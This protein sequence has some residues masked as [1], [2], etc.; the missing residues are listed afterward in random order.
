MDMPM[1]GAVPAQKSAGNG[2]VDDIMAYVQDLIEN[3]GMS[4]EQAKQKGLEMMMMQE[5]QGGESMGTEMAEPEM[6][7]AVQDPNAPT[8]TPED[9]TDPELE[10]NLALMKAK[11]ASGGKIKPNFSTIED[12]GTLGGSYLC[13]QYLGRS[14]ST[15]LPNITYHY[16]SRRS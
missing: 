2:T 16:G 11:K 13:I 5:G 6:A 14:S 12:K 1:K 8:L 9:E 3:Q 4:E 7:P 10:R 15:H